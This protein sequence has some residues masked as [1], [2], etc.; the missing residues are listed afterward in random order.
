MEIKGKTFQ[1]LNEFIF[2]VDETGKKNDATDSSAFS[3]KSIR[4]GLSRL[5]LGT[6]APSPAIEREARNCYSVK[7]LVSERAANAGA[8]EPAL[9]ALAC[10]FLLCHFFGQAGC[11]F[12]SALKS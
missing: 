10:L 1:A 6:R 5:V 12:F 3:K 11:Y 8:G 2:V 4:S 9:P 7:K